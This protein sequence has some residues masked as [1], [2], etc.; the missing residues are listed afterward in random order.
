[1]CRFVL[2]C[3]EGWVTTSKHIHTLQ[4]K[5]HSET[6]HNIIFG[7]Q[8]KLH[9]TWETMNLWEKFQYLYR[10]KRVMLF[11]VL[12]HSFNHR[13]FR[14][15]HINIAQWYKDLYTGEKESWENTLSS[16]KWL[17][18]NAQLSSCSK[19]NA[20]FC[21]IRMPVHKILLIQ[22]FAFFIYFG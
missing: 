9:K 6:H 15:E 8:S 13:T 21:R 2:Y 10:L 16:D 5:S 20:Y 18:N 3:S 22:S 12:L 1:M 14:N 4:Y 17:Y 11:N 7:S 19:F